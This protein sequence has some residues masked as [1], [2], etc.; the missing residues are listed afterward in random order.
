MVSG[1]HLAQQVMRYLPGQ[2]EELVRLLVGGPE[3][4]GQSLNH[5]VPRRGHGAGLQLA[6]V[7]VADAGLL[8]QIP[9]GQALGLSQFS[10]SLSKGHRVAPRYWTMI[11]WIV[12]LI[13][14]FNLLAVRTG[15]LAWAHCQ[16]ISRL[17]FNPLSP[18]SWGREKREAGGHPKPS[19]GSFCPSAVL[20]A[21]GG[22]GE[23]KL[24]RDAWTSPDLRS[25]STVG[26]IKRSG[27]TIDRA[28]A[29][30]PSASGRT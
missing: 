5:L 23:A 4:L 13:V 16:G 27:S 1:V 15:Q 2:T 20:P 3:Y 9:L 28:A 24:A 14:N 17:A 29:V 7:G 30:D 11:L 22:T 19:A 18:Q 12:G 8:R 25:A 10:D 21:T 6:D 26:W